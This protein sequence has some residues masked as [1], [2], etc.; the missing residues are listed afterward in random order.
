MNVQ[1][2]YN[3]WA[4]IK[5][6]FEGCRL[7]AYLDSGKVMT[8]GYGTTFR[9]DLKRK[10]LSG[11]H[12]TLQD[13]VRYMQ[14]DSVEIVRQA[15]IYINKNLTGPQSTAIC[16]YIYNRG[17]GNFLKAQYNTWSLDELI[18]EDPADKRIPEIIAGTGLKDRIGNL[19]R[20][21]QRRRNCEALLYK[22]GELKFNF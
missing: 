20:G 14:H 15:N 10:V 5:H 19:L 12:I 4:A 21:L 3:K 16:D 18:N 2:D 9:Y 13:A 11:D 17:I 7:G 6:E 22:T 1:P 8:I